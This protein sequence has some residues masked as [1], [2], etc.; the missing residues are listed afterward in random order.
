MNFYIP[1]TSDVLN[2]IDESARYTPI[3]LNYEIDIL[4]FLIATG[5][6]QRLRWN[7]ESKSTLIGPCG[8]LKTTNDS[9]VVNL[10]DR[11]FSCDCVQCRHMYP[12]DKVS[13]VVIKLPCHDNTLFTDNNYLMSFVKLVRTH[14]NNNLSSIYRF[15]DENSKSY[16]V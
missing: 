10:K 7:D 4:S 11:M 8:N 3:Q 9:L 12:F 13:D 14:S 2:S 6:L 1:S 16:S 15:V 5:H